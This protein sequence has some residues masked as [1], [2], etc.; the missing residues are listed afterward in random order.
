M[1]MGLALGLCP[2]LQTEKKEYGFG[3]RNSPVGDDLKES[4]E[5]LSVSNRI[6][7]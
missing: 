5:S 6:D 7:F 4:V 1:D 3:C 2:L